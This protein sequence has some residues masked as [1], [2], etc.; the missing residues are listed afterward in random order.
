MAPE[1]RYLFVLV[2]A[3]AVVLVGCFNNAVSANVVA[4][5]TGDRKARPLSRRLW[6]W[7]LF[8]AG[9]AIAGAL[10][11]L[12]PTPQ[13]ASPALVPS[14]ATAG[15]GE[16]QPMSSQ[17]AGGRGTGL[18]SPTSV[19]TARQ[20][21]LTTPTVLPATPTSQPGEVLYQADWTGG[22]GGWSTGGDW[23]AVGG[24]L[25]NTGSSAG[26]SSLAAPPYRPSTPDYAIEFEAQLL[27]GFG[28]GVLVRVDSTRVNA[29]NGYKIG[30]YQHN[31]PDIRIHI[32]RRSSDLAQRHFDPSNQWQSYR[33]EVKG[34]SITL[35]VNGRF[36][37][38]VMDNTYL[39][40]TL[41]A[42]FTTGNG[43]AN[44]RSFKIIAL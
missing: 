40:G 12:V 42:L 27:R 30:V 22:L 11:P 5:F 33:V 3:A 29:E 44:F 13:A 4:F 17:E 1:L 24:M 10:I 31:P 39:S 37:L 35:V 8:W 16:V 14:T 19:A 38:P 25:V 7:F 26:D 34:N 15:R 20:T 36:S 18:Q 23:K 9:V 6:L 43:Q 41:S 32:P 28:F 21:L 2:A